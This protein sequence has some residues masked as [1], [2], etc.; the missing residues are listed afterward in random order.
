LSPNVIFFRLKCIKF[1]FGWGFRISA[2]SDPAG[3]AY[4]AP[5]DAVA[6]FKGLY[7][8]SYIG[9]KHFF[10]FSI[11]GKWWFIE[12]CTVMCKGPTK[13]LALGP[14]KALIRPCK[15]SVNGEKFILYGMPDVFHLATPSL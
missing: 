13:Y 6:E 10:K 3:E 8:Q 14:L 9:L 12:I 5:P 1:D 7:T 11:F 2:R 4:S 15:R